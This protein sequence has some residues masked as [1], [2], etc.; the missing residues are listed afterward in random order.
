[1]SVPMRLIPILCLAA[2]GAFVRADSGDPGKPWQRP[3]STILKAVLCDGFDSAG[4]PRHPGQKFTAA[5]RAVV[6]VMDVDPK[7]NTLTY[8]VVWSRDGKALLQRSWEMDCPLRRILSFSAHTQA[9]LPIG[10]Y[11]VEIRESG[12]AVWRIPFVITEV[13]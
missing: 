1:M 4:Q 12:L 7:G 13:Q 11:Q 3:G 6:L 10:A 2:A 5:Q 9:H 8:T